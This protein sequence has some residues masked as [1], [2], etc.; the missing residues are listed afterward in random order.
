M[1]LIYIAI[2]LAILAALIDYF[3]GIA[4]P[5]RKVLIAGIVVLF[6]LGLLML[7][8]PGVIPLRA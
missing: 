8:L 2:V 4:E 6:I 1:N 5:W 7:L 3:I